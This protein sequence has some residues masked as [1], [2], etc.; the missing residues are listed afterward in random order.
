L[1]GYESGIAARFVIERNA[2]FVSNN[3]AEIR[4]QL[5]KWLAAKQAG[6]LGRLDPSVS[7]G[8]GRDDQYARLERLF[9]EV[10][11]DRVGKAP[12]VARRRTFY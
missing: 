4:D 5:Q 2:G 3:S 7:S 9:E 8:L 6:R 12:T 1:I 11:E 10:L